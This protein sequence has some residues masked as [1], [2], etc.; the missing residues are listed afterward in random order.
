M[1]K[2]GFAKQRATPGY[3]ELIKSKKIRSNAQSP[4]IWKGHVF[5]IDCPD[6]YNRHDRGPLKCMSLRGSDIGQVKWTSTD[7]DSK[8]V[9]G[10]GPVLLCAGDGRI[11]V[12]NAHSHRLILVN[13][14]P[15]RSYPKN[16][17][18]SVVLREI[19]VDPKHTRTDP[20]YTYTMTLANRKLYVRTQDGKVYCYSMVPGRRSATR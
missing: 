1:G 16:K 8:D 10:H 4:I 20:G 19:P 2:S 5:C 15:T 13:A 18:T 17:V 9:F 12:L 6:G 14:D 3:D 7:S 11:L